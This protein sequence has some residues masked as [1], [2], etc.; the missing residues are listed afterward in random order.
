MDLPISIL[1]L[2]EQIKFKKLDHKNIRPQIVQ[3]HAQLSNPLL[4]SDPLMAAIVNIIERCMEHLDDPNLEQLSLL[5]L[6]K[7]NN[8][9]ILTNIRQAPGSMQQKADA[10]KLPYTSLCVCE[11]GKLH[12]E[13]FSYSLVMV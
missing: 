12:N 2:T 7:T 9:R 10:V 5:E 6:E 11:S 8:P 3:L 13:V 1:S 4:K